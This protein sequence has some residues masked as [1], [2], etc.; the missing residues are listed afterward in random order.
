MSEIAKNI[1]TNRTHVCHQVLPR[2]G[3]LKKMERIQERLKKEEE[4]QTKRLLVEKLQQEKLRKVGTDWACRLSELIRKL[5]SIVDMRFVI[6][7]N[8]RVWFDRDVAG[9][10]PR[11][12]KVNLPC[13]AC[14]ERKKLEKFVDY[15]LDDLSFK[16]MTPKEC[17]KTFTQNPQNPYLS[18]NY[19][20]KFIGHASSSNAIITDDFNREFKSKCIR[21]YFSTRRGHSTDT[22]KENG[23][24]QSKGL[25][26]SFVEEANGT[27]K[28][29][30]AC[31]NS[32]LLIPI[33]RLRGLNSSPLSFM[34]SVW[35][36]LDHG[37]VPEGL[38]PELE[39]EYKEI[40][41]QIPAVKK[42]INVDKKSFSFNT[43]AYIEDNLQMS[44]AQ[45]PQKANEVIHHE[46]ASQI[47]L[48][49]R[50]L[51]DCDW[52]RANI[53]P[54][55][56]KQLT[57]IHLGHWELFE[58]LEQAVEKSQCLALPANEPWV[59]RPPQL[60]VRF[61][62]VCAIDFGTKSTVVVR[63]DGDERLL[64]IG[65][66]DYMKAVSMADYEN[67]T[68]IELRN[69]NA[70]CKAYEARTG[71]P[72]T[73]WEQITV[74]HQ[75]ADAIF[76]SESDSSVY[77][78][79]FSELK[80]WAN[81][82]KQ[83]LVLK[84]RH[85]QILELK[86]YLELV[87]GDFDPIE[88]YA[89]YL[90]LYINNMHNGICLD[91]I[92]SFPV[93]YV[94]AVRERL[95]QSFEKGLRKSLPPALL[96]DENFMKRFRVYAGASEPAAYAICA[97]RELDLE[98]KKVGEVVSYAVFDFGGGTTDFD[99]GIEQIPANHK[100]NFIVEQFGSGGD[101]YLGGENLLNILAYEVYKDNISI[102]RKD[103]IPIALPPKCHLFAGAEM[104]VFETSHASQ[105]AFMNCK[106]IARELRPIW[107]QHPDYAQKYN[108]GDL[109]VRLFSSVKHQGDDY[110]VEVQLKVDVAKLEQLI[111]NRIREGVENFFVSLRVAFSDKTPYPIHVFLAGNSCKSPVVKKLFNEFIEAEE[112]ALKLHIKETL[113]QDKDTSTA[114]VL[115]LPLGAV[116][117]DNGDG[118]DK[119][120]SFK[121]DIPN[122][123]DQAAKNHEILGALDYSQC[124]TGKTGVAFGLLRSR[125]GGKDVQIVNHN[126]EA[127]KGE[128]LFP[129]YLG[130]EGR[131]GRFQVL[132]GKSVPYGIW[133]PFIP[134]E[135]EE[136]EFELYYTTEPQAMENQLELSDV[137]QI[138]CYY[139]SM[140]INDSNEASAMV[141][142]RKVTPTKIE[143]T[144]ATAQGIDKEEYLAPIEGYELKG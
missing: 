132:V 7:K 63:R 33:Y 127:D 107:E 86:P 58:N 124:M 144:I 118:Q 70:F 97:L 51:L 64:R 13:Y 17:E 59:A 66:G 43:V 44:E 26:G 99:F 20:F 139:D 108:T 125:K 113:G 119:G 11:M 137:L 121:E 62:A 6:M 85:G 69:I 50:D 25:F 112:K 45:Y 61:N 82:P 67:P 21:W 111:E 134:A 89:Y 37:L 80:Q 3:F 68:V 88:T 8:K 141:Y 95:L 35:A 98:P 54:Y 135:I 71:R 81:S 131:T 72:F 10:F 27:D 36:W 60:D 74:S 130:N 92:L 140:N 65:K 123:A 83:R 114:F 15:K 9:L 4:I 120:D 31:Q 22:C 2:P 101:V 41:A 23:S 55:V 46:E 75:A 104:L 19:K 96:H 87:D 84:D 28:V 94:K 126:V 110:S 102:M 16:L 93:N 105:Q 57:D 136:P 42:Y 53:S 122:D 40:L 73:E 1:D 52:K 103:N 18:K 34:E 14:G 138:H 106:R 24:R 142:V 48:L 38:T 133:V 29:D 12:D 49:K 129:Y 78:S 143:Y 116:P 115:H 100:R 109:S 39:K 56:E 90:G 32:A 76:M 47:G 5:Q 79:V 30:A 117:R 91:Y 77:Y 128:V